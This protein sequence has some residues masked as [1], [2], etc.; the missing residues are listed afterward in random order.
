[1]QIGQFE[2]KKLDSVLKA[3]NNEE[4][5]G[6]GSGEESY[7]LPAY[8]YARKTVL[9][10]NKKGRK[11]YLFIYGDESP[12]PKVKRDQVKAIIGDDIPEDIDFAPN[13]SVWV[14]MRG[15]LAP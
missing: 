15:G 9:D 12:Y 1:M 4:A 11:G 2:T 13:G 6:G 10:A 8:F 3:I 5:G 7:E 14:A